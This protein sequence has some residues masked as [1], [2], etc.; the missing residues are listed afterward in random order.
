MVLSAA[1]DNVTGRQYNCYYYMSSQHQSTRVE[2]EP[3]SIEIM[4]IA[5]SALRANVTLDEPHTELP[6]E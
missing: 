4:L 5:V 1:E 3:L 6:Q 2:L